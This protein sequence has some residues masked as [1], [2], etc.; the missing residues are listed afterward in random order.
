MDTSTS[1]NDSYN[2][3]ES[4]SIMENYNKVLDYDKKDIEMINNRGGVYSCNKKVFVCFEI[5]QIFDRC[6]CWVMVRLHYLYTC[7]NTTLTWKN[8]IWKSS[9]RQCGFRQVSKIQW[10]RNCAKLWDRI[11]VICVRCTVNGG[12][13]NYQYTGI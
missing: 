9:A 5:I 12:M 4:W 3:L 13:T 1:E 8:R 11:V 6:Q 2:N 7:S 10:N